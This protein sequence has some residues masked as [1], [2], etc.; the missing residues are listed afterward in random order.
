MKQIARVFP[1]RTK[2]TPDDAL[3]FFSDPPLWWL[4]D[5]AMEEPVDEDQMLIG[6]YGSPTQR[7]P[8]GPQEGAKSI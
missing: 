8:T 2:A 7:A 5:T 1:R 3:A 4:S 6:E